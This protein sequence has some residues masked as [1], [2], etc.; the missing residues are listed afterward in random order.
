V[1]VSLDQRGGQLCPVDLAVEGSLK[2]SS[3]L[4]RIH[5]G[6]TF[7][8][9]I[10]CQALH[11]C[12]G[13]CLGQWARRACVHREDLP[14]SFS[15]FDEA[16]CSKRPTSHNLTN[17]DCLRAKI[18]HVQRVV[19]ATCA[20]YFIDVVRIAKGLRKA[21]VVERHGLSELEQT[22]RALRIFTDHV[23][24]VLSHDLELLKTA[25]RHLVHIMI[26]PSDFLIKP[27]LNMEANVM[28]E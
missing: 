7:C 21:T 20:R 27:I 8:D 19:V 28:P 11:I 14:I 17:S 26:D 13:A 6:K 22:I 25:A 9:V 3:S 1:V 15:V 5:P 18:D 24:H 4:K 10:W 23:P 16:D 12:Y 2:V